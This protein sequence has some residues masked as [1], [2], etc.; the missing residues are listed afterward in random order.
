MK[1]S[2]NATDIRIN[3]N[4]ETCSTSFNQF[5]AVLHHDGAIV[6]KYPSTHSR[7]NL[8]NNI[9]PYKQVVD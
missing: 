4:I 5:Q 8:H 3:T 2:T 7:T 1:I 9:K 6:G